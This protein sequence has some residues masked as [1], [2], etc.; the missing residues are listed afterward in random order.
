[1]LPKPTSATAVLKVM[2]DYILANHRND[3]GIV[4]CYSKKVRV[5]TNLP[6]TCLKAER[7]SRTPKMLPPDSSRKV[8]GRFGQA[9]IMQ[10]SLTRIRRLYT[11]DGG[12]VM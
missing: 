2:S 11:S 4:Y 5:L 10:L 8:E 1:M 7:T 6:C 3:S 12:M 9:F